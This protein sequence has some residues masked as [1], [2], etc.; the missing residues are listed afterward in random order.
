M[1]I[2]TGEPVDLAETIEDVYPD[3]SEFGK[4]NRQQVN[5]HYSPEVVVAQIIELYDQVSK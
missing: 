4:Q 2:R 5:E 3:R 1:I